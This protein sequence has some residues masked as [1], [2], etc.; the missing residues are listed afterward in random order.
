MVSHPE[1]R[2]TE[3][4][5]TGKLRS[6]TLNVGW[7]RKSPPGEYS[8]RITSGAS[9]SKRASP[10]DTVAPC[11]AFP[12]AILTFVERL[13]G[14]VS[15]VAGPVAAPLLTAGNSDKAAS[16]SAPEIATILRG[17]R[18]RRGKLMRAPVRKQD[19]IL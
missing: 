11:L 10:A 4:G 2:L 5:G 9:T 13:T 1:P 18:P 6:S 7:S 8:S 17:C 3:Y 14:E 19:D 15:V 12:S 16:A